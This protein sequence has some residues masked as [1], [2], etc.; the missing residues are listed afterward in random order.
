MQ[1]RGK[2]P[3]WFSGERKAPAKDLAITDPAVWHV[4]WRREAQPRTWD[5]SATNIE[6]KLHSEA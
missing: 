1:P 4:Y 3:N 5:G 6:S 2:T